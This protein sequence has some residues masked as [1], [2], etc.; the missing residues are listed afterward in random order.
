MPQRVDLTDE[1][2]QDWVHWGQENTFSLERHKDGNFA[3]L[4]GTPTAPRFRHALSEQQFSW[5]DGSPVSRSS[6]TPT[7]IRTCGSGNGFTLTTPGDTAERTLRLYVGVVQARGRVQVRLPNQG[8][9]V[10]AALESRSPELKTAVFTVKY[11]ADTPGTVKLSWVTE[12]SFDPDCGG[13]A[14]EAATLS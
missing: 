2:R 14:L 3:I 6:G 9:T 10:T 7:G 8:G 4:E 1:G 11:R 13:V 5:V 12:K